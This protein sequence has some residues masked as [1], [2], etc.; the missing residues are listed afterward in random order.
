[1]KFEMWWC[2]YFCFQCHCL[3]LVVMVR[4]SCG[5]RTLS[6]FATRVILSFSVKPY[7]IDI[8]LS[9][10]ED[11]VLFNVRVLFSFTGL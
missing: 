9:V 2:F 4:M 8:N 1:M 5:T 11:G 6:C 3:C 7:V 10:V